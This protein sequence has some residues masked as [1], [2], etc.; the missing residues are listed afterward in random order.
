[1]KRSAILISLLL[2][3]V[4][5]G[6]CGGSGTSRD[7]VQDS[8]TSQVEPAPESS[9][10]TTRTSSGC[11]DEFVW[12]RF[13]GESFSVVGVGE[14]IHGDRDAFA[15]SADSG[16]TWTCTSLPAS[17]GSGTL[18][19]TTGGG[20][21]VAVGYSKGYSTTDGREWNKSPMPVG[22]WVKVSYGA[23]RFVAVGQ[24]TGDVLPVAFSSDGRTWSST[25]QTV[26]SISRLPSAQ[27]TLRSVAFGDG[28]FVAVGGVDCPRSSCSS[29]SNLILQSRDGMNWATT[30]SAGSSYSYFDSVVYFKG[31][32]FTTGS[33]VSASCTE[34]TLLTSRDGNVWRPQSLKFQVKRLRTNGSVIAGHF[35][36]AT[37][38]YVTTSV[39]GTNWFIHG[40]QII[41]EDD[42]PGVPAVQH[43]ANLDSVGDKFLLQVWYRTGTGY[44]P[45]F[46]TSELNEAGNY[47]WKCSFLRDGFD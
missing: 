28:V 29:P 33:C 37:H 39:D 16:A 7:V 25:P 14:D 13:S 1:M 38:G 42:C 31:S 30:V 34:S 43:F 10:T 40:I 35:Q 15:L 9:T 17:D 11:G 44:P 21:S 24:T 18:D 6:S 36:D 5:V 46:L 45:Y 4:A 27:V 20:R 47:Q 32:F 41:N 26:S 3:A 8:T 23:G 12:K 22:Q 2:S 19:V